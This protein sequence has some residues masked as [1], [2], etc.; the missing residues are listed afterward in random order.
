MDLEKIISEELIAFLPTYLDMKGNCSMLY[1]IHGGTY[2]VNKTTKT[3]M[4][5]LSKYYLID[6]K[7]ARKYYGNILN[8]KNLTP[9]PFNKDN[10]FIPV[11]VRKPLCK[12][13][14]ALGYINIGYIKE[15]SKVKGNTIVYLVNDKTI[16][17]LNSI[18]TVN[19]HIKNGFIVKR[20]WQEKQRTSTINEKDIYEEYDRPATKRDIALIINEIIKIKANIK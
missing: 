11:K 16:R 9:I 15:V 12:N 7:N 2:E 14:G 4:K 13:D 3:I 6:I 19:K 18:E 20:L 17:C 5:Q 1:T 10:I 8:I